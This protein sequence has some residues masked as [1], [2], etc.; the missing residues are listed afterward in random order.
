LQQPERGPISR[1]L[2]SFVADL[3]G[4]ITDTSSGQIKKLLQGDFPA[5]V[6]LPKF[7]LPYQSGNGGIKTGLAHPALLLALCDQLDPAFA[8]IV[9]NFVYVVHGK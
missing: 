5:F 9:G 2:L 3:I 8:F 1:P 6:T 4:V 7:F